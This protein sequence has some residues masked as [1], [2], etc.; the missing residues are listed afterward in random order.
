VNVTLKPNPNPTT[1]EKKKS[2]S[3]RMVLMGQKYDL[4]IKKLLKGK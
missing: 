2:N 1:Y 4:I 3:R